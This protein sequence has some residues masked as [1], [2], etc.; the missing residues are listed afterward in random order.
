M[1]LNKETNLEP[2][3]VKALY[4]F[5]DCLYRER[6]KC[7]QITLT[8]GTNICGSISK[9]CIQD[10][11]L[12]LYYNKIFNEHSIY[13]PIDKISGINILEFT[14]NIEYISEE[15]KNYTYS[16]SGINKSAYD[17]FFEILFGVATKKQFRI[18]RHF[19]QYCLVA[20]KPFIWKDI[21]LN[22]DT[23]L[24]SD[25]SY[26]E[27]ISKGL[28][29]I[30]IGITLASISAGWDRSLWDLFNKKVNEKSIK[31]SD[32][33]KTNEATLKGHIMFIERYVNLPSL[34]KIVDFVNMEGGTW[35]PA[36]VCVEKVK[37]ILELEGKDWALT[38][39]KTDGFMF[40]QEHWERIQQK[41]VVYG[42]IVSVPISTEVGE[43]PFFLKARCCAY[44]NNSKI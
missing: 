10:N 12:E 16:Y 37:N 1:D 33:H 25:W 15:S 19:F 11:C 8:D 17:S 13:L 31:M 35:L 41:I 40:P 39:F 14:E 7:I 42:E 4:E 2:I 23:P 29:S 24:Y 34:E 3:D 30:G 20:Q 27:R 18:E 44:L 9:D 26:L 38:Y 43:I 36:I 28:N 22:I 32:A 5:I 21:Q 6:T